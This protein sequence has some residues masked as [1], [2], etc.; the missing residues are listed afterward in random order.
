M[1]RI[2]LT[3]YI[4]LT[5]LIILNVNTAIAQ[6]DIVIKKVTVWAD[7]ENRIIL[8]ILKN[9]DN[10]Y[11]DFPMAFECY[12]RETVFE[13]DSVIQDYEA[14]TQV[15]KN[16]YNSLKRDKIKFLQ[17]NII[18]NNKKKELWDYLFFINGPYETLYADVA[19]NPK[20]FII[21]PIIKLNFLK[22][23]HFKF[24]TYSLKQSDTEF[25]IHFKPNKN[26]KR[27]VFEGTII[28]DK[29]NY[30]IKSLEYGYAKSRIQRVN[31]F[32][33]ETE[34]ALEKE[35]IY[36]PE[37][38]FYCKIR[39]EKYKNMYILDSVSNEYSF[40]FETSYNETKNEI[41]VKNTL[42]V[43]KTKEKN[44]KKI[45]F[46]H[47]IP[48]NMKIIKILPKTDSVFWKNFKISHRNLYK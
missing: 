11:P 41:T 19:K 39:Y 6:K 14:V 25:I 8:N 31:N 30:A 44:I 2:N 12:F 17:A 36:I 48:R 18:K 26:S 4:I 37:T 16:P 9:I 21:I 34:L 10:N 23:R 7:K 27:A 24:Y 1:L 5:I 47:E 20:S 32:P 3:T 13:N 46:F 29:K 22:Q 15:Y 28:V 35:K 38:E 43:L 42:K 33:S 45:S 40:Q